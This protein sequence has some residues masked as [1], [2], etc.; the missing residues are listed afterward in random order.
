MS[1]HYSCAPANLRP[2]KVT[3]GPNHPDIIVE[4]ASLASVI[5]PNITYKHHLQ[6]RTGSEERRAT[7]INYMTPGLASTLKTIL[8]KT[9]LACEL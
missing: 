1:L 6:V 7:R 5:P 9:T 3:E 4:T 8:A 2:A